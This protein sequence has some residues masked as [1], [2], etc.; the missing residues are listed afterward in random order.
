MHIYPMMVMEI[1]LLTGVGGCGMATEIGGDKLDASVGDGMDSSVIGKNVRQYINRNTIEVDDSIASQI[2]VRVTF[3]EHDLNDIK[4]EL[5]G[6]KARQRSD[7]LLMVAALVIM[8]LIFFAA[9]S[10]GTD[11]RKSVTPASLSTPFVVKEK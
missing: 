1:N 3:V 11:Q 6:I 5:S 9:R 7:M 8:L 2:L 4:T 10:N